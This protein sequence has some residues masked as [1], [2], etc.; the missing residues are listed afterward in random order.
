[1]FVIAP[2]YVMCY[3]RN[4]HVMINEKKDM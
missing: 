2:N 4:N 3:I 1:M